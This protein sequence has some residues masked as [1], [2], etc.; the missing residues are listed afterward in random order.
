[1]T[2]VPR[3]LV[4][5]D[6]ET[7]EWLI[8]AA[9]ERER[10]IALGL[11]VYLVFL[12]DLNTP[13]TRTSNGR[14]LLL[15]HFDIEPS[16]AISLKRER[17]EG[18]N[19]GSVAFSKRAIAAL[20]GQLIAYFRSNTPRG[21]FAKLMRRKLEVSAENLQRWLIR[22]FHEHNVL[23]VSCPNGRLFLHQ[24]IRDVC[25]QFR[26][27]IHF[28]ETSFI[29]AQAPS[30]Y[31]LD[32]FPVH[33]RITFFEAYK[34]EFDSFSNLHE[35]AFDQESKWFFRR[36][37]PR[38]DTNQFSKRFKRSVD[39]AHEDP[40]LSSVVIF[41]SS[42]D[43]F[44]NLDPLQW[45]DA[46]V[47]QYQSFR[48][49]LSRLPK[50]MQVSLRIH[51]NLLNKTV[52][53]FLQEAKL[54]RSLKKDF[55]QLHIHWPG[56]A[57]NS[58]D[59]AARASL[60]IVSQ[61]TMGL[62]ALL[63]GKSVI[64]T[65]ANSWN[66]FF[67]TQWNPQADILGTKASKTSVFAFMRLFNSGAKGELAGSVGVLAGASR[68]PFEVWRLYWPSQLYFRIARFVNIQVDRALRKLLQ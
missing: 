11:Q 46:D 26:V 18:A 25:G 50:S 52:G 32:R 42:S 49:V 22:E 57:A 65:M 2:E 60:V 34:S 7:P 31:Y 8:V 45:P 40:A 5:V 53:H 47:D 1:M 56:D 63:M 59:L 66:L 64:S 68:F 13:P 19:Q 27:P 29:E 24:I 37:L 30:A 58:Y 3:A 43:E 54:V 44:I 41:T 48:E 55:P 67:G 38:S 33:D 23:E 17:L 51:P 36:T 15:K 62:E 21:L 6:F 12:S 16:N 20:D 61:S 35:G 14:K 4:F 9:S 39:K 28:T 10:L